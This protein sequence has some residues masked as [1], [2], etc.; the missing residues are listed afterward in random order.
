MSIDT[1][2]VDY[3][4]STTRAVRRKLDLDRPV[5]P[6]VVGT[7][8]RLSTYAPSPGNQQMWRWV[9]V[10]DA[11]RRARLGELFR[12]VGRS[13]L[14]GVRADLGAAVEYPSVRRMVD[15]V[16]HLI[17]VIDRVPVFVIPCVQGPRPSGSVEAASFYGGIYPAVWSFQLALRSRGLGTVLTTL[18]LQREAEAAEILCLPSDVTQVGLLP[19][20]YTTTTDFRPP[21][22][23]PLEKV[24]FLDTWGNALT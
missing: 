13:Y 6:E 20:A 4:L 24:A 19:V 16:Q 5:E 3:V 11:G 12:E 8:L 17:D 2:S 21:A 14:A 23:L 18:H 1:K 7:C 22:R 9:V 15:S 10:R